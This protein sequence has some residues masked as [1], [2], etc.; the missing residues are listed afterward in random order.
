METK[1]LTLEYQ[2]FARWEDLSPENQ[3]LVARAE[4]ASS[5][6]YS[7]Y[8]HFQ[9]G[10]CVLLS[11]GQM[12]TGNNQENA[13]YPSGLCAERVAFFHA[14]SQFPQ[15]TITKVAIAAKP[16]SHTSFIPV[17]PCGG[18]RQV[19][20]EYEKKFQQPIQLITRLGDGFAVFP[21]CQTLMPF[22]FDKFSLQNS[23]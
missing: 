22:A 2:Y 21:S 7:P 5:H 1:L 23:R 18:C 15:L 10:A 9:V 4:E 19:M 12:I 14:S 11:D 20:L 6:A 3:A 16:E 13:A 17:N 8:S